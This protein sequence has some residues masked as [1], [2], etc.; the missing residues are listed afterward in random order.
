MYSSF[1]NLICFW[2]KSRISF[3]FRFE[4]KII[5]IWLHTPMVMTK[6]MMMMVVVVVVVIVMGLLVMA[7]VKNHGAV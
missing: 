1:A 7:A 2:P 4:I 6:M 3:P 5:G